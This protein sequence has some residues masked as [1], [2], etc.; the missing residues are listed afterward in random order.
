MTE[1]GQAPNPPVAWT[2][3]PRRDGGGGIGDFLSFRYLITPAFIAV[4]YVIG[5]VFIT[6]AG[7]ATITSTA[8]GGGPVGGVLLLIL[9]NLWWRVVLEFV[10]V[11][12]RINASLQEIER[13]GRG[14]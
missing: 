6:L 5:A 2:P 8:P 3:Q 1:P 12:F 4:I 14:L 11:L 7:L 13:R 10:M 9:G